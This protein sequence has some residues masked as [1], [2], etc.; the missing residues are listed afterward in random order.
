MSSPL[1]SEGPL[2]V[3]LSNRHWRGFEIVGR[4]F[5]ARL[6]YYLDLSTLLSLAFKEPAVE[7]SKGFPFSKNGFFSQ[8]NWR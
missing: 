7:S 4:W 3:A 6:P 5:L 1:L 8:L 2:E